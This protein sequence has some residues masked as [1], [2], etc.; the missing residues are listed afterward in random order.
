VE[1]VQLP[2]LAS[3]GTQFTH[4]LDHKGAPVTKDYLQQRRKALIATLTPAPDVV[5][6]ELFPFGRRVLKD[7]FTALLCAAKSLP[8]APRIFCSIRDILAPPSTPEKADK[9]HALINAFYTGVLVHS[10]ASVTP[11]ST[12]WPVIPAL[13]AKL[14]YTGFVAPPPPA[15]HPQECGKGE[16][17]VSA[18]GGPVGASLFQAACQAAA[19]TPNL[20][21]RLL[22]GGHN[23][24][25]LITM[26]QTAAPDTAIIEP[27]RPDFR[28]MLHHAACSVSM[29]GYNTAL[30]VLQTGVPAVFVPFDDGG[31]VEQ[32]LRAQTLSHL[33]A[34]DV[35]PTERCTPAALAQAV[36]TLAQN[37]RRDTTDLAMDGAAETVRIV[38]E[39][40]QAA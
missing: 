32:S 31:E 29:S 11:L 14:H 15:K 7:E 13:A 22:I 17:I 20:T 1:Y 30:D 24:R 18:G 28:Q 38:T 3:D 40:W 27:A 37:A 39:E 19:M 25:P 34:I 26:L 35:L 21:W 4:L 10:D 2:A 9:T 23:P 16:I 36:Q 5:I 8:T 6:T 12:S 33:P